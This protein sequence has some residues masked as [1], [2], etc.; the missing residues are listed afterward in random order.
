MKK[1]ILVVIILIFGCIYGLAAPFDTGYITWTQPN[2]VTF[3]A[4]SWGDEFE[5]W[6]ETDNGYRIINGPNQYFYYAVLDARGEFYPSTKKVGIHQPSASSYHLERTATRIAQIEQERLE[7]NEQLQVNFNNYINDPRFNGATPEPM[8]VAIVLVDFTPSLAEN[9]DYIKAEYD[10]LF[11]STDYYITINQFSPHSPDDE[12]V[13]GSFRDYYLD[14]S[15]GKLNIV[16]KFG[17]DRSIINAQNPFTSKP[18]RVVM[19]QSRDYYDNSFEPI[20]VMAMVKLEAEIQLG[21]DLDIYDR[22]GLIYAGDG[23]IYHGGTEFQGGDNIFASN[24]KYKTT[25]SHIGISAH[26][27][28]H[29]LGAAD[30]YYGLDPLVWSLMATGLRN[31]PDYPQEIHFKGNCPAPFSPAYRIL[32][33]WVTPQLIEEPI[34]NMEVEYSE[35]YPIFYKI[36]IPGSNEYFIVERRRKDRFD[37]YTPIYESPIFPPT[38]I[39]I[40]HFTPGAVGGQYSDLEELEFADN[41]YNYMNNRFPYPEGSIQNFTFTSFPSSKKRNGENSYV[42]IN[43]IEWIGDQQNGYAEIDVE[44][45]A[46]NINGYQTWTEDIELDRSVFITSGSTLE[47]AA[48][49][50]INCVGE[51]SNQIK[52]Y[53][54][55]GGTLLLNGNTENEVSINSSTQW[56]GII[57]EEGATFQANY[58]LLSNATEIM[59]SGDLNSTCILSHS[60]FNESQNVC[61]IQGNILVDNSTF[62]NTPLWIINTNVGSHFTD[63]LF[64]QSNPLDNAIYLYSA[65]RSYLTITNCTFNGFERALVFGPDIPPPWDRTSQIVVM[66]N[67][68]TNCQ[69]SIEIFLGSISINFNDFFGNDENNFLGTNY[70]LVDPLYADIYNNNFNLLWGSECIDA[71]NPSPSYNDPDGTRNDIGGLF[72]DQSPLVPSGFF[73]IK[74]ADKHPELHWTGAPHLDYNVYATY[75]LYGGGTTNEIYPTEVETY[76]DESIILVKPVFANQSVTYDITSVN[77]LSEE[78]A[79]SEQITLNGFGDIWKESIEDSLFIPAEF[80]V[81]PAYPN[82]FNPSTNIVFDLPEFT[83]VSLKV[84]NS[85]GEEIKTLVNNTLPAGRHIVQFEGEGIPSGVY[86]VR[87]VSGSYVNTQKII[88]IK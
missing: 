46:I 61:H 18:V 19:P 84:F 78:S 88:L 56:R 77:V 53:I 62:I 65:N 74:D 63:C 58:S 54:E 16:G 55:S 22:I 79:H 27:F 44:F 32:F 21:I 59:N 52:F 60:T 50:N 3:N 45:T 17:A 36:N 24:E 69:K 70:L 48:G 9:Y 40:W 13:F 71:G 25:F 66:N 57:L 2:G 42:E 7:F 29:T 85:I 83:S 47:V 64:Y 75:E 87:F 73:F 14:Q 33:N 30:E 86:L 37:L 6:M 28:A 38:G 34:N 72:Y 1:I 67:I 26:E 39:I 10:T 8:R 82:P 4:R 68:I 51:Y 15:L 43:N 81:F 49:V 12:D 35:I 80:Y 5:S 23:N 31:G 20:D 11:F 41:Q 76:T